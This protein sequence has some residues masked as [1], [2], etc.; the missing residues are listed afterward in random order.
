MII[1]SIDA[2]KPEVYSVLVTLVL[3][4]LNFYYQ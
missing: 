2:V 1:D 3:G 4:D